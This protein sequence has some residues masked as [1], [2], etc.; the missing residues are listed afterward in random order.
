M[1]KG[2]VSREAGTALLNNILTSEKPDDM[3]GCDLVIEA[4]FE[5]PTLKA[6]VTQETEVVLSK[7]KVFASN[8]STIPITQLAEASERPENFI[9]IHFFSPVDKMPLVEII[10]GQ[11]T[12]AHAIA[13]AR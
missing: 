4:V 13:A 12:S 5:N 2:Y 11:K 3:A 6:K 7:N 1:A 10:I 8:T 9:G